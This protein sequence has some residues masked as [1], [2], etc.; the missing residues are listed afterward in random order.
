MNRPV[1]NIILKTS[2]ASDVQDIGNIV[3][4]TGLDPILKNSISDI[5]QNKYKAEVVQVL[6]FVTSSEIPV[7]NTTY[8]ITQEN[9][10]VRKNSQTQ[11]QYTSTYT[12]P[13]DI[14]TIGATAALQREFINVQLINQLN[15]LTPQSYNSAVTSTGGAGIVITDSAGYYPSNKDGV[16][17]KGASAFAIT[18]G[19]ANIS[20]VISV[21]TA[22]VYQFGDGTYLAGVTAVY[23]PYFGGNIIAG[24]ADTPMTAGTKT[25]IPAPATAGQFY[26]CFSI[27]SYTLG[28]SSVGMQDGAMTIRQQLQQV[29]VDNGTGSST[30]N[31][32]GFVAFQREMQRLIF[33]LYKNNPATI[34]DF[35]DGALIA[36]A[37]YP[38]TGA[39]ITTTDNV[40]MAAQGSQGGEWYINPIGAHTLLTPIVSTGGLQLYLDVTTQEGIEKSPAN[41]TQCPKEVI[42]G[43]TAATYY[44]RVTFTGIAATDWKTFS[45]GFRK[46]AAYAVDQTAYEAASVATAAI[47]VPIDTGVAP[48]LNIIT[49]PGSAGVLT[50]TSTVVSPAAGSTHDLLL[51]LN[52][53]GTVQFFVDGVDKTS[54]L[55]ASYKFTAGVHVMPFISFRYGAGAAANPIVVQDAFIPS[56]NWII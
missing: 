23:A 31:L 4:I 37:T 18:S 17:R 48:V 11:N 20:T 6:T 13:N 55:A 7:A 16:G 19:F 36:S 14:T 51:K 49:G 34:Y 2:A 54:L 24:S 56:V 25:T 5:V 47:G 27:A 33:G 40:V 9:V 42:V 52:I 22:P 1:K 38:T 46:K 35:Y 32:A 28:A 53:D 3:S 21:T 12:T 39:A 50:N 43:Q 41:L 15:A 26:D 29:W 8:S 44:G 10:N 45:F 30:T